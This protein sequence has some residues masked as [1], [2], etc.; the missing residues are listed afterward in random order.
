ME[1]LTVIEVLI[2][3]LQRLIEVLIEILLGLAIQNRIKVV[4]WAS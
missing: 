1:G 3:G 2:V 4:L